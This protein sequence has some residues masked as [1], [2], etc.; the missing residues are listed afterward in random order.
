MKKLLASLFVVSAIV[1]IAL[2]CQKENSFEGGSGPSEGLLQGN[3]GDCLPKLVQGT[4]IEGTALNGNNDYIQVS[5]DVLTTGSYT[6]YSDTLNGVFFRAVGSFTTTGMQTINLRGNGVPAN[7]GPINFT[8]RYE[9][10]DCTVEVTFLPSTAGGPAQFT[11]NQTGGN[12]A[13][14]PAGTYTL[15]TALVASNKVTLDVTV[16]QIGTYNIS[17]TFQGMTFSSGPG[18]FATTGVHT[19]TLQGSGTP[20]VA[21]ANVVPIT[22]GTSTCNFTITVAATGAT[23][24]LGGA[25]GACT[26]S[27]VNGTYTVGSATVPATNTVTVDVTFATT[28][29]YT[30]STNTVNGYS[31]SATG[32]AATATTVPIT[33]QSNGGT[34]LAPGAN[35]FTVTFGTS[36]CTFT[37]NVV[38]A[39]IDYFPRTANS[40]WSYEIDDDADDS[41]RRRVIAPTHSAVGNTFNIFEWYDPGTATWDSGGYYRKQ[42]TDYFEW[43]D[44]SDYLPFN[45]IMWNQ[46]IFLKD[47]AQ[48]TNWKTSGYSGTITDPNPPN[49]TFPFTARFSYTVESKDIT[50]NFT[51]STGPQTFNNVI[52]I[53]EEFEREAPVGTWTNISNLVG[54]SKSYYARGIG[55]IKYEV[56]DET[57]T[58]GGQLELRRWTVLP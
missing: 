1:F 40:N 57:G 41:L 47:A 36:T 50:V 54:F 26:P 25:G 44:I 53:K 48:N 16:T 21:G 18:T 29:N 4:Y 15:N 13:A 3:G 7:D 6:I 34:P 12:C 55:L 17:T 32:N 23:G 45:E 27:T 51:T 31:F 39:V 58:L 2:S 24:T 22:V 10:Q 43:V 38:A 42:A 37:V 56:Y 30:I 33:L 46:F 9:D 11:L 35:V 49:P 28:G 52:V 19:V 8:I 20:T 14:T 5:V